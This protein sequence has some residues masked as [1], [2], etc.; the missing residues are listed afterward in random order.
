VIG[1]VFLESC[2]ISILDQIIAGGDAY[3]SV[4]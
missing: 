2:R 1:F 3:K 4:V